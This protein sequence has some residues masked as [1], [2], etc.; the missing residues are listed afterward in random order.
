MSFISTKRIFTKRAY[1]STW[2]LYFFDLLFVGAVWLAYDSIPFLRSFDGK[3]ALIVGS[4]DAVTVFCGLGI[5]GIRLAMY[6][7]IFR[8]N[9]APQRWEWIT[10]LGGLAFMFAF[11]FF[12]RVMLNGWAAAHGYQRCPTEQLAH[13]DAVFSRNGMPCPA[14]WKGQPLD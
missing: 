3:T 1:L 11:M 5:G 6:I 14:H 7:A 12:G 8:K 4:P 13:E 2:P 10:C 9:R